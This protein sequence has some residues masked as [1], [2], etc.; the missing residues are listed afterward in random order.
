ML[1]TD[2]Q[3]LAPTPL[4]GWDFT[5]APYYNE[6]ACNNI[7]WVDIT[8]AEEA[9]DGPAATA[10]TQTVMSG[11]ENTLIETLTVSANPTAT[12]TWTGTIGPVSAALGTFFCDPT[13]MWEYN[14]DPSH[15]SY[16]SH[17]F[18]Q[19]FRVLYCDSAT[20]PTLSPPAIVEGSVNDD[21]FLQYLFVDAASQQDAF[22]VRVYDNAAS[23]SPLEWYNQNVPQPNSPSEMTIDGYQA[24]RDGL[25]YYI[26]ASNI[27]DGQDS[28]SNN[29]DDIYNNIYLFT[30]ND[31][32]GV[33]NIANQVLENLIFNTNPS[34][35]YAACE[36]SQKEKL[37]R[38]T[39]RISD[40][41]SI[42][43]QSNAYFDEHGDFPQPQS[44]SFGS[45]VSAI[46]TSVWPSWQ[47]ALGNVLE[48]TLPTDPYNFFY[49]SD[50]PD[51]WNAGD[52]P[53][54]YGGSAAVQDC[55]YDSGNNVYYDEDGSCWDPVNNNFFCPNNSS[56]Y[57]YIRNPLTPN[58]A[59]I[60][61][62]MEYTSSTTEVF[63]TSGSTLYD[64]CTSAG[65]TNAECSCY[66]YGLI[67]QPTSS[68]PWVPV[69]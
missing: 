35:S 30:F 28:N 49:A 57:M 25:S 44:D 59:A 6:N 11:T 19:H 13:E 14:D 5:W 69:P 33:L 62:R 27:I 24:V 26:S 38:D 42:V 15:S 7:A 16:I 60:Y 45:F 2:S 17:A 64:P 68:G 1:S 46:T 36:G 51:P 32:P 4:I 58:F 22:G 41:G 23:L 21:W 54:V 63:A 3:P 37:V 39:K 48:Q 40:I 67:S 43:N 20:L 61:G 12:S 53:W 34:I 52:E 65:L 9:V 56:T 66:N 50:D 55:E 31:A 47:G 29:L 8:A 10:E 18:P